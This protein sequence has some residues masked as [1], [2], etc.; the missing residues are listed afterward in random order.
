[1]KHPMRNIQASRQIRTTNPACDSWVFNFSFKYFLKTFKRTQVWTAINHFSLK[2]YQ[3]IKQRTF[4]IHIHRYIN[5]TNFN[6]SNSDN[7]LHL[8][9]DVILF[10]ELYSYYHSGFDITTCRTATGN[11]IM[12][13]KSYCRLSNITCQQGSV[14]NI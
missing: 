12:Q 5:I 3:Y 4:T 8:I 7:I 13:Y 6:Y 1:M 11:L 10:R 14:I 9:L 2:A